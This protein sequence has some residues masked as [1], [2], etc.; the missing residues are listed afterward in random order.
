MH[1]EPPDPH[2]IAVGDVTHVEPE[3]QPVGQLLTPQLEHEPPAHELPP[4]QTVHAAPA[5]PHDA[6]V[7]PARHVVPSQQPAH[8]VPSQ[9]QL[10]PTQC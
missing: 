2:D 9:T 6:V 10:P 1:V 3:Q 5:D 8:D 7:L 4:V